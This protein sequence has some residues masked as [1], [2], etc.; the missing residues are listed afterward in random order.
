MLNIAKNRFYEERLPVA[1]Y[2]ASA[3]ELPFP[4]KSF[5]LVLSESVT[6]FTKVRKSLREYV[7][8]LGETGTFVAIEIAA[9]R[10]L[11]W[12]E[13]QDIKKLYGI[14]KVFTEQEWKTCFRE[15]GFQKVS[16]L[17]GTTL[18]DA[19][20]TS[21][22][23]TNLEKLPSKLVETFYEHLDIIYRYQNVLGYRVFLCQ[24][25]IG[26]GGKASLYQ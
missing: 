17:G 12:N 2:F 21:F 23:P 11:A 18:R 5:D 13:Q 9:E 8:V 1:L 15:A 10:P 4:S 24:K 20:S 25:V 22:S 19:I 6:A 3:E 7:R 14:E 16:I 26:K